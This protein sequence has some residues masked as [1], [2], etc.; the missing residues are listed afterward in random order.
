MIRRAFAFAHLAVD[1]GSAASGGQG[2]GQQHM[3]NAQ[4]LILLKAEHPVIPPGEAFFGLLEQPE[5]VFKAQ[6]QQT[7]ES[8]TLGIGTKNLP[9]P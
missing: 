3:V 6:R 8:L 7:A 2:V 1:P 5:A 9:G 4:P